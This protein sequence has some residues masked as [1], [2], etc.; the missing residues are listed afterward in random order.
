MDTGAAEQSCPMVWESS[1][2]LTPVGMAVHR[3]LVIQTFRP[4]RMLAAAHQ[5]V[6]AAMGA[7]FLHSAEKV[8]EIMGSCIRNSLYVLKRF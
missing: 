2:P 8:R 3:L 5:F 1:K 4:D 7:E 6:V